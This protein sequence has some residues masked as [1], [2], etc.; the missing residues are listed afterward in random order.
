MEY[1]ADYYLKQP[2]VQNMVNAAISFHFLSS[3]SNLI[4][5]I[6]QCQMFDRL[7]HALRRFF[8]DN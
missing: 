2:S 3:V 4:L 1:V 7:F 6:G 8:L 5:P